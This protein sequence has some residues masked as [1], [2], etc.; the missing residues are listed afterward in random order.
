[1]NCFLGLS[2]EGQCEFVARL[3]NLNPYDKAG[4]P[5]DVIEDIISDVERQAERHVREVVSIYC[6]QVSKRRHP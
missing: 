1:M 5:I 4:W 6:G 2:H 3:M